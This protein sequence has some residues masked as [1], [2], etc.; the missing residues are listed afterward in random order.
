MRGVV[1]A[2]RAPGVNFL[3]PELDPKHPKLPPDAYIDIS[4]ES[5]IRQWKKLSEWLE[6]EGARRPA[7]APADRPL[8]PPVNCC[9]GANSPT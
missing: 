5:L 7:M 3:V 9:A 1:D 4:H 2:F 8:T 6:K